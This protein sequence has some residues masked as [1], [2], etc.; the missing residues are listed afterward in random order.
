MWG[1]VPHQAFH[2]GQA[3]FRGWNCKKVPLWKRRTRARNQQKAENFSI[4]RKC[5]QVRAALQVEEKPGHDDES[6]AFV[7]TGTHVYGG[8]L[9]IICK[10]RIKGLLRG[11][12]C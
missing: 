2:G 10:D 11:Q 5:M 3:T 12:I 6:L 4:G 7:A 8:S 9:N 1:A